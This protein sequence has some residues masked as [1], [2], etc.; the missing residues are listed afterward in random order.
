MTVNEI[1]HR[2]IRQFG[3]LRCYR[4]RTGVFPGALA[5]AQEFDGV[6]EDPQLFILVINPP[7]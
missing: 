6:V 1:A 4:V 2:S 3:I 7:H 5:S